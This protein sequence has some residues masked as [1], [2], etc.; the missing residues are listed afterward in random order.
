[1]FLKFTF[2]YPTEEVSLNPQKEL[3]SYIHKSIGHNKYHDSFSDYAIS[4]LLGYT[5][6]DNKVKFVEEP[7]IMVASENTN[8]INDI[9]TGITTKGETLFGM[10]FQRFELVDYSVNKYYDAVS[11]ISPILLKR[12]DGWKITVND[13]EWLDRL[14]EQSLAKLKHCGLTDRELKDFS[15][16]FAHEESVGKTRMRY[17]GDTFNPCSLTTLIVRGTKKARTTLYNLGLGN[18]CGSG[19]GFI[20]NTKRKNW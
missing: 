12:K 9:I 18:S 2:T 16:S 11:T 14:N 19:F 3:N 13:G 15:I 7:Y 5:I 10:K 17:V 8:F 6:A 20:R 4:S 1:M